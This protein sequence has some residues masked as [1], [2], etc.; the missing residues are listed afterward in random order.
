[1]FC[2]SSGKETLKYL[3]TKAGDELVIGGVCRSDDDSSNVPKNTSKSK[4]AAK[5]RHEKLK[6]ATKKNNKLLQTA[7]HALSDTQLAEQHKREHSHS[8]N[9]VLEELDPRLKDI[10]NQLNKLT[11][12]NNPPKVRGH[13]TKRSGVSQ[14]TSTFAL[15]DECR[16]K[17]AG[18]VAYPILVGEASNIYKAYTLLHRRFAIDLHV[19]SNE[20]ALE[21]LAKSLPVWVDTAIRD[22]APWAVVVDNIYGGGSQ[23]LPDAVKG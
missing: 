9:P 10:R 22:S 12:Q 7:T 23:I 16:V 15:A 11:I 20:E 17:K 13:N 4:P 5:K 2:S 6:G 1:M 8:M 3:G 21:K 18:K 19:C 14:Q